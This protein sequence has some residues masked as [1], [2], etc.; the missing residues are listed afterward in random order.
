MTRGIEASWLWSGDAADEP[1]AEGAAVVEGARIVAVGDARS[2]RAS[3]PDAR[4]ER[5]EGV[6]LPGLVNARVSLELS[7]LRGRVA[8]GRGYVPWLRELG[9]ARERFT[10]EADAEALDAAVAELVRAGTA[11]IGEVTR[12]GAAI[13]TLAS[14]PL[15]ARVFHEIAGLRRET[16]TVIRAMAEEHQESLTVPANVELALAPHSLVGLHPAAL[17]ALFEGGAPIPLPLASSPAERAYLAD[18]GGPLAAWMRERGADPADWDAPGLAPIE[19]ARALGVLGPGLVATHLTDA[20]EGEVA[21]LAETGAHVVLCP[22]ASLH[23]EVK[24]PPVYALLEAG[25]APGLGSDSLAAAPTLDVLDDALALHRRFPAIAPR[26]VLAMA[27]SFGAR[28]LGLDHLVGRLA[29]GLAPG[30]LLFEGRERIDDPLAHVLA[31]RTR[32]VLVE[33]GRVL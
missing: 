7:A 18:G 29:P 19:H 25:L 22:R 8:G 14:A 31:H 30:I 32:R 6:L 3:Y 16:A 23:I 12:T 11:A 20:R 4:W 10:P 33:P 24:L 1:I 27:T 13:E 26:I 5:H 28:A 15:V 21:V 17:V 9:E 2:L